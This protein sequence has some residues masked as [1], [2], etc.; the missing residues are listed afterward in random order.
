MTD[1]NKNEPAAEAANDDATP[2]QAEASQAP[3]EGVEAGQADADQ[4]D[5]GI[6]V[7]LPEDDQI[8]ELTAEVAALKDRLVRTYA[9]LENTRKRA[10][11]DRQDALKFGATKFARDMCEVA[12]NLR[13][14]LSSVPEDA[15][16]ANLVALTEGVKVTQAAL[17]QIFERHG[18]KQ[19]E[20][21]EQKFDPN[22][23]EAMTEIEIPGAPPGTCVDVIEEGYTLNG[24][25]LRPARV[26][27]AKGNPAAGAAV[28]TSA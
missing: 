17:S 10:E 26:V 4:A 27:V 19:I 16:D 23:H 14:A 3:A 15:G 12:D 13:R 18:V 8:A 22:L 1:Q 11:R 2:E 6:E 7:G 24:R 9:D 28:D 25:L 5:V 20:A 21:R